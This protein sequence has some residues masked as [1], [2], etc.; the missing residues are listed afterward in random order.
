MPSFNLGHELLQV[1]FKFGAGKVNTGHASG[2]HRRTM[3]I[4]SRT[5]VTDTLSESDTLRPLANT[6][7][8]YSP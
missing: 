4:S 6:F 7:M 2:K 1:G 3:A 8:P 5:G